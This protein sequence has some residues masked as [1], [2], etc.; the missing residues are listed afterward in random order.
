M[1]GRSRLR[2][3]VQ[4]TGYML[5]SAAFLVLGGLVADVLFPVGWTSGD[6][7]RR[8]WEGTAAMTPFALQVYIPAV[9]VGLLVGAVAF[10]WRHVIVLHEVVAA[11]AGFAVIA[12]SV[13][14]ALGPE[15][16]LA[17]GLTRTEHLLHGP[18]LMAAGLLAVAASMR[19]LFLRLGHR[20]ERDT[21]T[22]AE[23]SR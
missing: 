22:I 21:D 11:L 10:R 5:A 12:V 4:V 20:N 6:G 1:E 13:A 14:L 15:E 18:M 19:P 7:F 16:S 2:E 23:A 3:F 9:V 17:G 8:E